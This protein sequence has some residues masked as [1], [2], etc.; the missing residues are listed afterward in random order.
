MSPVGAKFLEVLE[1]LD[2]ELD[3]GKPPFGGGPESR[4]EP[5]SSG[6]F[7]KSLYQ[8]P[9]DDVRLP[10]N[11]VPAIDELPTLDDDVPL[12]TP[13][14]AQNDAARIDFDS[15][16][17]RVS[18]VPPPVSLAS[19]VVP[20]A[21]APGL[22]DE[23]GALEQ[24]VVKPSRAPASRRAAT[25][26]I[27]L[28]L[29]GAAV[30]VAAYEVG[31]SLL[32]PTPSNAPTVVAEVA[33]P[34]ASVPVAAAE[35]E[36][37]APE[38][39]IFGLDEM[40]AARPA[41]AP[42]VAPS[43]VLTQ[44]PGTSV[45][46]PVVAAGALPTETAQPAAESPTALEAAAAPAPETTASTEGVAP[47]ATAV[48]EPA[49]PAP[50]TTPEQ[51]M[52]ALLSN[53]VTSTNGAAI[54]SLAP[55][56]AAAAPRGLAAQP[57]RSEVVAAMRGVA[58]QVDQCTGATGSVTMRITFGADGSV[59]SASAGAPFAGTPEGAC[60][61]QAVQG[62]HVSPFARPTFTVSYPFTLR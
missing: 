35:P 50:E 29:S 28:A 22:R 17:V 16:L 44:A 20:T 34:V 61:A 33:A 12:A 55:E 62:A 47:E 59:R 24:L 31:P 3:G 2:A 9:F 19:F 23:A 18:T 15:V 14:V 30:G 5:P 40:P 10:P 51:R 54:A 25:F 26:G 13:P 56:R 48:A 43:P 53:A 45:A 37:K 38:T 60:M 39:M 7:A 57:E 8:G 6:M 27:A 32:S 41:V 11:P 21:P 42:P 36:A 1:N 4:R 58:S 49:A 52:D 46:A